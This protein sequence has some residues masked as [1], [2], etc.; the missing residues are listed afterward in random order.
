M[1]SP[2]CLNDDS[3]G[4]AVQGCRGDF[5]FTQK[6][7]HIVLSIVPASVLVA[8]ASARIVILSRKTP[9]IHGNLFKYIKIVSWGVYTALQLS[10]LVVLATGTPSDVHGLSI[11]SAVLVFVAAGISIPLSCLEHANAVKPSALLGSF[12]ALTILFDIAQ[13][14]TRWLTTWAPHHVSVAILYST[15]L[16]LKIVLLVLEAIP[17]TRWMD[18]VPSEHS[19]EESMNMYTHGVWSWLNKLLLTG[20]RTILSVDSLYP[21][22]SRIRATE[23]YQQLNDHLR[24]ESCR[25][26][27]RFGLLKD[28]ART[29]TV[30]YLL[31]VVPRLAFS[32]FKF[33]QPLLIKKTL[34]YL[35]EDAN[36]ASKNIGY[37][38]IGAAGLVYS[39]LAVSNGFYTYWNNKALY[40]T[41]GCLSAAIYRKTAIAKLTTA[42]D[43]A[44]LTLMSTD[45]EKIIMGGEFVHTIWASVLEVAI[46]LWLLQRQVGIAFL[47]PIVTII[48]C[49]TVTFGLSSVMSKRQKVWM[50][51]IEQR[52]GLTSNAIANMKLCKLSGMATTVAER[53]QALRVNEIADGRKMRW[54]SIICTMMGF[55]PYTM[56]PTFT[57]AVA[58][59]DLD[60]STI[61]TSQAYIMLVTNPI[62]LLF[63]VY[64]SVIAALACLQRI[65]KFL[66]SEPRTDY[67]HF[68]HSDQKMGEKDLDPTPQ[69]GQKAFLV[70]EG[71]AGWSP[72]CMVLSNVTVAIPAAELTLIVGPVAC[73]KSTFCKVLLGEIPFFSG[74]VKVNFAQQKVAYCEQAAFLYN[75]SLKQN[76]VGLY[77]FD[78][79]RYDEV[80]QATLLDTDIQRLPQGSD[81]KLGSDGIM[82]SGGQR[83]RVAV[84]RALYSGADVLIFDDVLSGLDSDTDAELFRR[85]FGTGGFLRQ[86]GATIVVC[87]H[88]ISHLPEADHII[89]FAADG[90]VVEQG[91]F[92]DLENN[93]NYIQSL[94]VRK[95]ESTASGIKEPTA[96]SKSEAEPSPKRPEE[97]SPELED[98]ARQSGDWSVYGYWFKNVHPMAIVGLVIGSLSH[99]FLEAFCTIW[100]NYWAENTFD[101]SH[102]FYICVLGLLRAAEF[103]LTTMAVVVVTIV[104]IT[105]AGSKLH[106]AAIKTVATAPLSFFTSTDTGKVTNLFSQDMTMIDGA[107]LFALTNFCLNLPEAV[108]S[109]FVI[110]AASP[111]L[112]IGYPFLIFILYL[113]QNFYLRTSRQLRLLDLETKS[114]LYTNFIDTMKGIATIRAYRWEDQLI[115]RNDFLLDTSQRPAYLLAMI[116]AWL[117]FVMQLLV[118]VLAVILFSLA[119]Q[120][121]ANAGLTGASLLSLLNFSTVLFMLIR[122]YTRLETCIGAVNRLRTFSATVKPEDQPGEDVVP[123]LSWPEEGRIDIC[124]VSA[125]F[126]VTPGPTHK[127]PETEAP[128]DESPCVLRGINLSI[129]AGEKVALCGRTGSGKSSLILLL[130]RLLEPLP[131]CADNIHIDGLSL[132]SISRG[133]LRERILII[134]QDAVFLPDGSSIKDHVDPYGAATPPE[135]SAALETVGLAGFIEDRGGLQAG[136]SADD[137][138][139]GQKQ[140]FCLGRAILRKRVRERDPGCNSKG[141]ILLLDEV[142]SNVDKVTDRK[143]QEIIKAEFQAY[144]IVMVSH[145]LQMVVDYFDRVVV[146]DK[147]VVVESGAPKQLIKSAGSRFGEL[148]AISNRGNVSTGSSKLDS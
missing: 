115:E 132:Q 67:R 56:A 41:R 127:E 80:I 140:L 71:S 60:V 51:A 108:G 129:A 27:P 26:D 78:Q 96:S 147:G 142:S 112:A 50:A 64:P 101:K 19:P 106:W 36:T 53:I 85:V 120:L 109:G 146:L 117:S 124:H 1:S 133:A 22:D 118:A 58:A 125:S 73:G 128:S 45:I 107:L 47:A 77:L 110:A 14:R 81:T 65:Q 126:G 134:P 122:S 144:T 25:R 79:Q 31:P 137:L 35:S 34:E 69:L 29:L 92:N 48:V 116:Q 30:P 63:Q 55:F 91:S 10:I 145:R 46:G 40:Q 105:F 44:A 54:V 9:I 3:F 104:M 52:V 21:L 87:T 94:G 97:V 74:S 15:S 32:G 23:L 119:T 33:C 86:R 57:Y 66:V 11:A 90:T 98:T 111:Y 136:M 75:A 13:S 100:L 62:V 84:A 143:M 43:S 130:G 121:R 61:F 5:D 18:W 99:G 114:P 76:I 95:A 49:S 16:G 139:A 72:D 113:I 42:D 24:I 12:L 37:G 8:F 2:V 102:S 123:P 131:T 103:I 135:C 38:L 4:P 17:K 82:L 89:A 59:Q 83:Q 148:W 6:F 20:N 70:E 88:S 39:M 141:G 93:Q 138:S 7:E 68:T 28:L